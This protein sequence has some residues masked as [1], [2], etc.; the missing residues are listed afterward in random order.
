MKYSKLIILN[1][2]SVKAADTLSH[3]LTLIPSS[4]RQK[5]IKIYKQY[6]I[7]KYR[8]MRITEL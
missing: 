2:Q 1:F 8:T 3:N 6:H 4:S 7:E 5:K